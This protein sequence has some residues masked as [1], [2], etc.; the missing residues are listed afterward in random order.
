MTDSPHIRVEVFEFYDQVPGGL[1]MA[2]LEILRK[3]W[4]EKYTDKLYQLAKDVSLGYVDC[5]TKKVGTPG[6]SGDTFKEV[7]RGSTIF[8]LSFREGDYIPTIAAFQKTCYVLI[9]Q[10]TELF[11]RIKF[12]FNKGLNK[13]IETTDPADPFIVPS[14]TWTRHLDEILQE[15]ALSRSRFENSNEDEKRRYL[16]N[17]LKVVTK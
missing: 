5:E 13:V 3:F 14:R 10:G 9:F 8:R 1:P 17:L 12:C 7:T 6:R 16:E 2:E 11:G 15:G 4:V